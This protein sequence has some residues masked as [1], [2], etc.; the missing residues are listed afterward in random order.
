MD[1]EYQRGEE[2][3]NKKDF[4]KSLDYFLLILD[5][6]PNFIPALKF[7]GLNLMMLGRYQD[8][9]FYL[10]KIIKLDSKIADVF[11]NLAIC[12]YHLKNNTSA[13]QNF[14]NA[15]KVNNKFYE[16]YIQLG[17][18][19]KTINKIDDAIKIYTLALKNLSN[20]EAIYIN[21]SDLYFL[22]KNYLR[23]EEFAN[24]AIDINPNSY[25]AIMN[26]GLCQMR[27][28]E[29][30]GAL[31]SLMQSLAI[32]SKFPMTYNYIGMVY[33]YM[34]K[35]D[36]AIKY[37]NSAIALDQNYHDAYFNLA[38]IQL[39]Q[40]EFNLGWKNYEHRWQKSTN[41][42][43]FIK[44]N[45]P[46]WKES[47]GVGKL[48]IWGEQGL[49]DVLLFSSILE[50]V[51]KKFKTVFVYVD[52]RICKFLRE[53]YP[54]ISF[55]ESSKKI[56]IDLFDFHL[57]I[58]SLGLYFRKNIQDFYNKNQYLKIS[59]KKFLNKEKKFRCGLSWKSISTED[60]PDRSVMLKDL[61]KI[62]KLKDIEF[63]DIQ[64]TDEIE[65]IKEVEK[66]EGVNILRNSNLDCK[67][68]IYSL[69]QFI[70][71]CDF[72]ITISNTNVHLSCILG[73]PT[74]VLLPKEFGNL[75]YWENDHL[76]KNLWYPSL[77]KFK[78]I[79]DH[80]WETPINKLKEYITKQ[81]L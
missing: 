43:T 55:I 81:Y 12:N 68:D 1:K 75:W 20:Y 42:P 51:A 50:D 74:F 17:T 32:N 5:K 79:I 9:S 11:Y 47:M 37:L 28:K 44:L 18:L 2:L 16:A 38:N 36:L 73:K 21:L 10:N 34:G 54:N 52:E 33:R 22:K 8:A 30:Y 69:L 13:I 7:V 67:N 45:K 66:I 71:T 76:N 3:F 29:L 63:Y 65:E 27:N 24:R 64:Y 39:S 60:G 80:N 72:V 25:L 70:N 77:I 19:Y 48:L 35:Y 14:G 31:K 4:K 62:L 26:K 58:C 40:N 41:R 61:V 49:G 46:L 78:Q 6:S 53:N 56:D 59:V 15:I 57:P 23:S